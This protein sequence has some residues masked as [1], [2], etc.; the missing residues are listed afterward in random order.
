MIV[1]LALLAALGLAG[2]GTVIVIVIHDQP[3]AAPAPPVSVVRP[4][5][6]QERRMLH[7]LRSVAPHSLGKMH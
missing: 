4:P 3:P 2:V 6:P 1:K 5:N 7:S